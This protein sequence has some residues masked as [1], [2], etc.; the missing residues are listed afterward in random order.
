[1]RIVHVVNSLGC[2]GAENL[3][4]DLS[5]SMR[6]AG[7]DVFIISL[8]DRV[9]YTRKLAD[10][11]L[12]HVSCGFSGTIYDMAA[13]TRCLLKVRGHIQAFQP[14]II[15]SHIFMADLISRLLVPPQARHITT[16]HRDEPW[17]LQPRLLSRLKTRVEGF[18]ARRGSDYFIAVSE[19][20]AELAKTCLGLDPARVDVVMNGIDTLAFQ[21]RRKTAAGPLVIT[22]VARFYPEKAHHL[23]IETFKRLIGNGLS[24]ELR[25]IGDGPLRGELEQQVS[26]TGLGQHIRFLGIR[27]DVAALLQEADL[28]LLPSL[29][30][31]LPI[32]LLEAMA[33]GL[34]C[35]VSDVGEM[36]NVIAHG[37]N[38]MVVSA[39]DQAALADA[40]GALAQDTALAR[41]LGDAARRTV[42]R[43]YSIENTA[44][45]Y[46]DVYRGAA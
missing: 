8:S 9:E 1:M 33:T 41:R 39:G 18:S 38:G 31:G 44:R 12:D 7:H 16:L 6:A 21:P 30:E 28:F 43:H 36:P 17:W 2:G 45:S 10:Y 19:R 24:A 46:L 11:R 26:R 13:L 32:S 22:H 25:L 20:A 35:V 42:E 14:D 3:V 27:Q 29:R 40:I 4:L 37:S 5:R 34:P 15:H 23:I